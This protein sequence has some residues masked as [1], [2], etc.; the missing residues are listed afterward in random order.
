MTAEQEIC[1]INNEKLWLH[2]DRLNKELADVSKTFPRD[3]VFGVLL[4]LY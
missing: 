2:Q 3:N 4:V 1:V